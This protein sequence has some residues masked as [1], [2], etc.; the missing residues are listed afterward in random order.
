MVAIKNN[1]INK[2]NI[3]DTNFNSEKTDEL[4]AELFA[5]MNL[6]NLDENNKNLAKNIIN[7]PINQKIIPELENS[8]ITN[9]KNL[10]FDKTTKKI[11][12]LENDNEIELAKS[13][14]EVF[15]KE[16]GITGP[17]NLPKEISKNFFKPFSDRFA[18]ANP[19][20]PKKSITNSNEALKDSNL[21]VN[22]VREQN[23]VINII[24]EPTK[25]K[26][27]SKIDNSLSIQ[28]NANTQTNSKVQIENPLNELKNN[29]EET[30]TNLNQ[31]VT[32]IKKK[33]KK[34]NKQFAMTGKIEENRDIQ[35]KIVKSQ[36]NSNVTN[37]KINTSKDNQFFQKKETNDKRNFKMSDSKPQNIN[38]NGKDFLDLLESSWGEK[39]SKIIKSSV[40]NGL[41]KLQIQLKPKNLGKLN[42]EVSV[43][44]NVTSINIG[45]ENQ[46]VVTL[47][48]DNLPKLIDT[49]DKETKSFSSMMGGENNQNNYFNDNKNNKNLL[50]N[51]TTSDKKEKP[52]KENLKISNHN[53]D[54]KA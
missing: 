45:S 48:N 53:I 21:D 47:L 27:L 8:K 40:N 15:Y 38:P 31:Q 22:K 1:I 37:L 35:T 4:F 36:T 28:K 49:I 23:L 3:L 20:N 51:G 41:N 10:E 42:L 18:Q 2:T 52:K 17:S 14:I 13:L 25:N 12:I 29:S 33:N 11:E 34:K 32:L 7:Q 6:E 9:S 26:K 46:E 19:N 5:L 43:K 39:F 54:V 44:N 50:S 30:K 16:I 24:K